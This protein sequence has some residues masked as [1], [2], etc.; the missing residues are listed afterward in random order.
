MGCFLNQV[1]SL[2]CLWFPFMQYTV[3]SLSHNQ[4]SFHYYPIFPFFAIQNPLHD[5]YTYHI[6][7]IFQLSICFSFSHTDVY[8][9]HFY[10]SKTLTIPVTMDQDSTNWAHGETLAA[11][12][13]TTIQLYIR[14]S[15][16]LQV[17]L[18]FQLRL[19]GSVV[20]WVLF[21]KSRVSHPNLPNCIQLWTVGAIWVFPRNSLTS[22]QK[23]D[24][25]ITTLGFFTN[26]HSIANINKK[27]PLR[28][29]LA[30]LTSTDPSHLMVTTTLRCQRPPW[31][32]PCLH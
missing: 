28:L 5:I 11:L 13:K 12:S 24:H 23:N 21:N 10:P 32:A 3:Y 26:L 7:C 1:I 20:Q 16:P 19:S 6:T 22:C 4:L 8:I 31:L 30:I 15:S 17:V 2:A 14:I 9:V 18:Y 27:H 29:L 25:T